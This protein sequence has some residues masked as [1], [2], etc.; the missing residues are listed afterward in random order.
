MLLLYVA[1]TTNQW[2]IFTINDE[3]SQSMMNIHKPY[4]PEGEIDILLKP[5]HICELSPWHAWLHWESAT[6]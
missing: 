3:Y 5:P 1:L 6:W 4:V 2:W